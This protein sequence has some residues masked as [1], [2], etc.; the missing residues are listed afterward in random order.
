MWASGFWLGLVVF[1]G[2]VRCVFLGGFWVWGVDA[3]IVVCGLLGFGFG[4]GQYAF[5][6]LGGFS[7]I[8]G[9]CVI[10]WLLFGW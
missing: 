4:V 6:G 5:F 2:M 8:S 1:C 7:D 10:L 3:L 9:W